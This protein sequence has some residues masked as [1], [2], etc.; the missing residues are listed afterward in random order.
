MPPFANSENLLRVSK[1]KK[2]EIERWQEGLYLESKTGHTLKE[3]VDRAAADRLLLASSFLR[4]AGRLVSENP[5]L[6]RAAVSRSYYAM[7]HAMR[8]AAYVFHGGDDH[9]AHQTLPGKAPTDMNT[10][11]FWS[12][13]LKD[14]RERRNAADYNPYPKSETAWRRP[15]LDLV[16]EARRFVAEVRNYLRMK[17]CL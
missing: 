5:P 16:S 15:A 10:P 4:D 3:L 13:K 14:A 8:A 17:G 11:D 7:Y 9:E 1:A 6:Y 12:N 2:L